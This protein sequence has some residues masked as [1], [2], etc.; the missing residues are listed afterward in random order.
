MSFV[1]FITGASSGFGA[2][3]AR[4][5]VNHGDK[6]IILARRKDKLQ[7]LQEELGVQNCAFIAA[8]V[9]DNK[10]IALALEDIYIKRHW[11]IDV[12]VNNAG[13]ARG[14]TSA[15]Q[16]LLSDWEE[17]IQTNILALVSLTHYLLPKMVERGYGHIV[18]MGSIA[19]S[20]PYPGGNVYGATKAFVKQFSLNLRADLYDKNIRVTDIEPGLAGGSEFSL[21]RFKGDEAKANQV[22]EGT[23]PLMPKDIAEAVKWVIHLPKHININRLEIMPTTQAP[24]AL[25]VHKN[26]L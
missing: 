10:T 11:E 19:G 14:L 6:V 26:N 9:N 17:M 18:N 12:L 1:V 20:Y 7:S 22:Y 15:N 16:S 24:A 25:N 2:E 23:T 5:L 8:D 4:T 13:L 3:I 21:V